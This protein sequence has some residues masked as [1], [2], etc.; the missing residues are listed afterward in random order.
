MWVTLPITNEARKHHKT[1][2]SVQLRHSQVDTDA[3]VQFL[4]YNRY[5]INVT[6]SFHR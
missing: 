4:R 6:L 1:Q 3:L 2:E 5:Q